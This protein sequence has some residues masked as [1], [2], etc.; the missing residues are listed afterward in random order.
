MPSWNDLLAEVDSITDP[1]EGGAWFQNKLKE[2]LQKLSVKRDN[3]NV[4]FYASGFLQKPQVPPILQQISH[5]DINGFMSVMYGMDWEKELTLVLHTPGG[6]TNAT[7]TFT[8]AALVA[9]VLDTA[10]IDFGTITSSDYGTN[11]TD[12]NS[13]TTVTNTGNQV[14]SLKITGAELSESVG[15]SPNISV[16]DFYVKNDSSASGALQLTESQQ[17]IPGTSVPLED[18]TPGGN[19]EEIWW[20]FSVPNPFRPG[21]YSG[22]WTLVE[23]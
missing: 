14:L 16:G 23:E 22:T 21:S 19:I 15:L 1:S 18:A 3:R 7:E 8:Y 20:F 6:V 9:S 13:P 4:I 12:A 17:T 5:E 11:K 2:W 10:T